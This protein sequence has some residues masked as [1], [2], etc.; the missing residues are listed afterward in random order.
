MQLENVLLLGFASIMEFWADTL[1]DNVTQ[2]E[3]HVVLDEIRI[4]EGHLEDMLAIY[5]GRDVLYV[6]L[7]VRG[8]GYGPSF[9]DDLNESLIR[10]VAPILPADTL[11]Q[12]ETELEE[13]LYIA[14]VVSELYGVRARQLE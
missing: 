14:D 8:V 4:F 10:A 12:L 13:Y 6:C 9:F 11:S 3:L 1:P 2:N 7:A 5:L